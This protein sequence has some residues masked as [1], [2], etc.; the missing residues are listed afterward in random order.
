MLK[1]NV[2]NKNFWQKNSK[3]RFFLKLSKTYAQ[4]YFLNSDE[5]KCWNWFKKK[6]KTFFHFYFSFYIF[7][8]VFKASET[9]AQKLIC[10]A[11]F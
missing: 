1:K 2:N 11:V 5:K 6:I 10:S 7:F 3:K 4:N 9:Y 8:S